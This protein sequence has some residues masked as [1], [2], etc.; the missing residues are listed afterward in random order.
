M[1]KQIW[2]ILIIILVIA[3]F[4][5]IVYWY[6]GYSRESE[7]PLF[8]GVTFGGKTA[9][10]AKLLIDK[11]K[12]YTNFFLIDS[13]D[14]TI[15]ETALNEVCDYTAK[16]NLKFMVFFSFVSRIIYPWHQTWLDTAKT[17]WGDKFLGVYLFDEPGGNQIDTGG[18]NNETRP[19][20]ENPS[21]YSEASTLF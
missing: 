20:F 16:A 8:F 14:I 12:N 15:N 17:R 6:Y 19:L 13:H 18:W 10:E 1:T 3:I 5:P 9:N 21:T 11:V 2:L 7:T 4:S